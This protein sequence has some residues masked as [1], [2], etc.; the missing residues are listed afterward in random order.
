M[1]SNVEKALISKFKDGDSS[2]FTT[3][4][5]SYYSDL[6]L[7]ASR[8]TH[9][10]TLSEEIVQDFFVAFWETRESINIKISLKSYLL[11]TIQNKCI[12]WY[13]HEKI[14][15]HYEETFE[16]SPQVITDTD[17][18]LLFSELNEEIERT[19]NN[20]PEPISEAFRLNRVKGLKYHEIASLLGVSVRT[21]EV[22]IG[23]ALRALRENLKDYLF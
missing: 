7:F 23:K 11:K 3:I 12:D 4:F 17:S 10:V 20:L 2:S 18:Y 8:Y 19:L 13:R 15:H 1:Y 21:I 6:V 5:F 22:R 9:D 16:L 14:K